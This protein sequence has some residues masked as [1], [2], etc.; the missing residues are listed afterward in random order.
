MKNLQII[1]IDNFISFNKTNFD[2]ELTYEILGL[3]LGDAPI[4]L[5][6]HALTGNSNLA[7]VNGV[8]ESNN[9]REKVN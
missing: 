4:V 1:K 2:I 3:P 7:G 8:V 5:V 9:W 6:N